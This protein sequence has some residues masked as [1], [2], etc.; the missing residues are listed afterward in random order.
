MTKAA[1]VAAVLTAVAAAVGLY[2]I[3]Q[4]VRQAKESRKGSREGVKEGREQQRREEEEGTEVARIQ[5]PLLLLPAR[6]RLCT[7]QGVKMA[8]LGRCTALFIRSFHRLPASCIEV[9]RA[10]VYCHGK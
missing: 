8:T 1:E 2:G 4:R 3:H 9:T 7:V 6:K 5:G 10:L